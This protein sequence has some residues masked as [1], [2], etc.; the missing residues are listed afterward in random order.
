M[1]SQR[2]RDRFYFEWTPTHGF[3]DTRPLPPHDFQMFE[4]QKRGLERRGL[5]INKFGYVVKKKKQ[6]KK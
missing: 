3:R 4:S 2:F 5:V 1:R 6:P